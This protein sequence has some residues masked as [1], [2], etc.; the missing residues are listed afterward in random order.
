MEL[1]TRSA[2]APIPPELT[3]IRAPQVLRPPLC[4]KFR[5]L[6][7][8]VLPTSVSLAHHLTAQRLRG[9]SRLT[10]LITAPASPCTISL[11]RAV[12]ALPHF[13]QAS[14]HHRA[15]FLWL[16]QTCAPL[17]SQTSVSVS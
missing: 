7:V 16:T 11:R 1:V 9:R 13:R 6:G 15:A 5:A 3:F 12:T 2:C 4:A 14:S 8:L 10:G 17:M